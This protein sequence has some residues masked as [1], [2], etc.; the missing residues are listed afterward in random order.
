[1]HQQKVQFANVLRGIAAIIVV[2]SHYLGLYWIARPDVLSLTGLPP[3]PDDYAAPFVT[4]IYTLMRPFHL[5]PLGVAIFF[6]ISG[7]VIPFSFEQQS[8]LQFVI[9][10]FFRIWPTYA[11][12]FM[13]SVIVLY[14]VNVHFGTSMPFSFG[15]ALSQSFLGSRTFTGEPAA[16]PVVWTLELE[17]KFYA[18]AF[19]IGPLLKRASLA[20]F[21]V[22]AIIWLLAFNRYLPVGL[23]MASPY[24]VYMF[25]GTTLNFWFRGKLGA[26]PT[27]AL[28]TTL[29]IAAAS[30]L[31]Q[32]NLHW[33]CTNYTAA[34]IIF[35]AGMLSTRFSKVSPTATFLADIS[36]PFYVVHSLTG[37]A[38][39]TVLILSFSVNG[40]V[41]II[42]ALLISTFFAWAIHLLVELPTQRLGKKI[43]SSLPQAKERPDLMPAVR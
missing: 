22:P 26:A 43:A 38:V 23:Y 7:F 34:L 4:N 12:G 32:E 1:M 29:M 36:Y 28:A 11:V 24:L 15:T 33:W 39:M 8:R 40:T 13:T 19:L 42:A 41:A 14:V 3:L 6:L 10:R 2:F 27:A 21:A 37:Y 20:C 17:L 5:G 31:P 16:D 18:L 30:I 35:L 9:T 25:V